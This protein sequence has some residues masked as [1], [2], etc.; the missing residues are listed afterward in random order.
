M[1]QPEENWQKFKILRIFYSTDYYEYGMKKVKETELKSEVNT[2]DT[3]MEKRNK[4]YKYQYVSKDSDNDVQQKIKK[5]TISSRNPISSDEKDE[6][7]RINYVD[8][9]NFSL[10]LRNS[11]NLLY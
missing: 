1:V 11:N 7:S 8:F 2:T 5:K 10:L 4:K 3:E 6:E 9:P